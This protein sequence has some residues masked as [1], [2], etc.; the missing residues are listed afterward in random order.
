MQAIQKPQEALLVS[1][2]PP[3][4][5]SPAA[6][7]QNLAL[8]LLCLY[9]KDLTFNVASG[10]ILKVQFQAHTLGEGHTA[11]A[12]LLANLPVRPPLSLKLEL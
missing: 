6:P 9:S 10:A 12:A 1:Q 11:G 8:Q 3:P 2:P 7:S 4:P 5:H